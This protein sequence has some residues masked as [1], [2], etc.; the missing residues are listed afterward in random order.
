MGIEWTYRGEIFTEDMVANFIGFVYI[1]TNLVS[2]KKY[3][4][5]K[6][7]LSSRTKMI[8][9]KKKK[10]KVQSNWQDYY[11]SNDYLIADVKALGKEN[12]KREIIHLCESK[13]N[14]NYYE[15]KEQ[16]DLGVLESSE[17]YNTWIMVRVNKSHLKEQ[18]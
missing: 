9:G 15:A 6:L 12:F 10:I 18:K 13:G 7:F 8:K 4:G 2:N 3:V 16:F 11:G 1:I 5:K 14:C 17:Y